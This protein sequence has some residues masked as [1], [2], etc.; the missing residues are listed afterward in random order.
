MANKFQNIVLS[1]STIDKDWIMESIDEIKGL[2]KK[3]DSSTIQIGKELKSLK[4]EINAFI[5]EKKKKSIC[6]LITT[7]QTTIQNIKDQLDRL[8][9]NSQSLGE[10]GMGNMANNMYNFLVQDFVE[11]T[12][13]FNLHYN[14]FRDLVD[15][16][17][18]R[19]IRITHPMAD[20]AKI[21]EIKEQVENGSGSVFA[22]S[23]ISEEHSKARE[24]LRGYV[25]LYRDVK[26]IER[27]IATL[28]QFFIDASIL[29]FQQG[30]QITSIKQNVEKSK[31]Y[32]EKGNKE[33]A[34]A[35]KRSQKCFIF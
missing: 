2:L 34:Q 1:D 17:L 11:K 30:E 9:E 24:R 13:A 32:V 25:E 10:Y 18:V 8:K 31:N 27:Q 33:L 14:A 23:F 5:I 20:E 6:T 35:V 26:E 16:T 22:Q 4:V 29:V 3:V 28:K 7:T 15:E 21:L 19:E 12:S